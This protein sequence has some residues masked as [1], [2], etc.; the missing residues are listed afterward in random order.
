METVTPASSTCG[1]SSGLLVPAGTTKD[2]S[3][4]Y[5][6]L[7]ASSAMVSREPY[8]G[9][10]APWRTDSARRSSMPC[11]W[12]ACACVNSTAWIRS[13]PAATSWSRSSGGVSIR[14]RLPR[15]SISAAV[16]VRRSRGS[17]DVQVGQRQPICGTPNDV[18]V[19]SKISRTSHYLDLDEV[20]AARHVP[21]DARRHHDAIAGPR[22]LAFENEVAHDGQHGIIARH[23]IDEDRDHA[24]HQGE[25]V[26]RGDLGGHGKNGNGWTQ[27]G[28]FARREPAFRERHDQRRLGIPATAC[29]PQ[30]IPSSVCTPVLTGPRS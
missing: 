28:N 21:G 5:G 14:S 6:N 4:M 8:A 9:S 27:R 7:T 15:V 30:A 10:I 11:T 3:K 20:G 24:P 2:G 12:W 22:V 16:R 1:A 13:M 26:V 18:P 25:L 19:P 17:A 29:L 23:V